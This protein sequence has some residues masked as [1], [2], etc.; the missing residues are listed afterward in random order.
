[1]KLIGRLGALIVGIIG[2]IVGVI[3]DAVNSTVAHLFQPGNST[4]GFIVLV[5]LIVGLLG[6][7][8]ALFAP[9]ASGVLLVISAIG[10][11]IFVFPLGIIPAAILL[12]AAL[13]AFI[14]QGKVTI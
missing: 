11:V 14:D 1:M 13:L 10:V 4:H 2:F 7:L 9:R 5:F 3:I 8:I 6:S 12:I